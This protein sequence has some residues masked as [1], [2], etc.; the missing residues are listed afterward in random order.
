MMTEEHI[1]PRYRPVYVYDVSQT[2][3]KELPQL[4][5]QLQGTVRNYEN[6]MDILRRMSP[7]PIVID[8]MRDRPAASHGYCSPT[9]Q[10]IHVRQGMSETQTIKTTI[11]EVA[12]AI[13]HAPEQERPEQERTDRATREVQAESIAFILCDHLGIDTSEYTFDYLAGW[14]SDRELKELQN[15]LSVIQQTACQLIDQMDKELEQ[16]RQPEKTVS[17]LDARIAAAK[18]KA[19]EYN[20]GQK[21]MSQKLEREESK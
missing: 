6:Y 2:D 15:S 4:A 10:E 14:S 21:N 16:L 12:H 11:H 17:R 20:N 18:A 7:F 8:E 9:V 1:I 13:L 3:G 5:A 19:E